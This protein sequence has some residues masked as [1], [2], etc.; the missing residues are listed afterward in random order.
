MGT[1]EGGPDS[2]TESPTERGRLWS[3]ALALV[4]TGVTLGVV[5]AVGELAVRYRERTRTTVPD[6]HTTMYYQTQR[7]RH[8]LVRDFDYYGW[9]RVN[10]YGFRGADISMEKPQGVFRIIVAG[11]STTFDTAVSPDEAA[12]PARLEHWLEEGSEGL[13]FEVVNAGVSG[14]TLLDN[15]IRLQ[16]ELHRFEPDL[17]LLYQGHNDLNTAL[18]TPV[19]QVEEFDP[20]PGEVQAVTPWKRWLQVNSL[21]Y[22][23]LAL[24]WN[25]FRY[26]MRGAAA[27]EAGGSPRYEERLRRGAE[28]FRRDMDILLATAEALDLEVAVPAV[29]QVSGSR[30]PGEGQ[31]RE[32][33]A[34]MRTVP[35]ASSPEL[36]LRTYAAFADAK[37]EAAAEADV[38]FI[39]TD[40]FGLVGWDYY[41]PGDPIHFNDAGADRMGSEMARALLEQGLVPSSTAGSAGSN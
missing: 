3:A 24:R 11:A 8:A 15:I 38:P 30:V 33:Q 7:V 21:F 27:R 23:K 29:V 13:D 6:A 19:D 14:Y 10:R 37:R 22:N 40:G 36:V 32:L 26:Q 20:R 17:V 12:W 1:A 2:Q 18:G 31:P 9:A 25:V 41:S 35:G 28:K 34:W 4:V 5:F 39:E 16:T